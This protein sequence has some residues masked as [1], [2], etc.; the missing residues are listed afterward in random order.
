MEIRQ[1]EPIRDSEAL[2]TLWDA[3]LGDSWPQTPDILTRGISGRE[4]RREEDHL[5][6]TVDGN[7][8]GCVGVHVIR[9]GELDE[10]EGNL[11]ML[12]VA[13]QYHG[14]GIGSALHD[15]ALLHLRQAG[16]RGV[17]FGGGPSYLW[18]GVPSNLPRAVAF[19]KHRGWHFTHTSYDLTQY[20]RGYSTPAHIHE[21]SRSAG[22]TTAVA[23][24]AEAPDLLR[25]EASE[26]PEWS[27]HFARVAQMGDYDDLLVARTREGKIVGSLIMY[28][29]WSHPERLDV[30]WKTLLGN[31]VGALGVVGVA[32]ATRGRGIGS[33]LVARGSEILQ[34]R[35]VG[36]CFIGW[37]VLTEFYAKLGYTAWRSYEMARRRL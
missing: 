5:V 19:F 20:L 12:L 26:F 2:L 17:T 15:A 1:Y 37:V 23:T 32:A 31:D 35:G 25:F 36:T 34:A 4:H 14:W 7:V 16:A 18:Q 28:G 24:E 29:A 3:A 22:I 10:P 13:A 8:V 21:R 9:N 6:A 30:R 11:S 33:E 27:S